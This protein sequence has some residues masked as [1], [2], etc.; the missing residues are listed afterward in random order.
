MHPD[1]EKEKRDAVRII[2]GSCVA[3]LVGGFIHLSHSNNWGIPL[4]DALWNIRVPTSKRSNWSSMSDLSMMP[5]GNVLV[6][7]LIVGG[8]LLAGVVAKTTHDKFGF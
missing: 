6:P 2:I 8:L 3:V 5:L 1:D 7:V 4:I